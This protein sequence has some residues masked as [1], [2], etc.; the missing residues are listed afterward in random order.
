VAERIGADFEL[1]TAAIQ[2]RAKDLE[3]LMVG[4][5]RSL[6]QAKEGGRAQ[7]RIAA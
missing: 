3:G 4:C 6:Y 1:A 7:V 5:D 2:P